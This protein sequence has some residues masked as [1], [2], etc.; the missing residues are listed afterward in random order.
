[1]DTARSIAVATLLVIAGCGA[2]PSNETPEPTLTPGEFR[3]EN[4]V[5]DRLGVRTVSETP[6]RILVTLPRLGNETLVNE[7]YPPE[8]GDVRLPQTRNT[9]A[10]FH[11]TVFSDGELAWERRVFSS[12]GYRLTVFRNGT[13]VVTAHEEV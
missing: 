1:M 13:V 5:A 10:A 4:A 12:E 3:P 2:A 11:V 7:T 9:T 8:A 6:I